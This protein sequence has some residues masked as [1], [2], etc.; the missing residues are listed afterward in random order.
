MD[1]LGAA[2]DGV[3]A[4]VG[5]GDGGE[6]K[7]EVD[8]GV[9]RVVDGEGAENFGDVVGEGVGADFGA[10]DE[11]G[12][13]IG[14]AV[15]ACFGDCAAAE[16]AKTASTSGRAYLEIAIVEARKVLRES[17]EDSLQS[18]YYIYIARERERRG[19]GRERRKVN[20]SRALGDR[21]TAEMRFGFL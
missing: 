20:G 15:G 1:G 10:G 3:A 11:V 4:A 2:A 7:G 13:L 12:A 17:R 16:T 18:I 6:A 8:G 9:V 5:G 14:D 19:R 21:L